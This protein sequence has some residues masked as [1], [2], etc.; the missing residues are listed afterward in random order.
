MYQV[1][2]NKGINLDKLSSTVLQT[3]LR[4]NFFTF[5][6]LVL[7]PPVFRLL[8]DLCA[9]IQWPSTFH[10]PP[11]ASLCNG[12]PL[13]TRRFIQLHLF[14]K[15]REIFVSVRDI[16]LKA[17]QHIIFF[18]Q[19]SFCAGSLVYITWHTNLIEGH[20]VAQLVEA[21]RYKREGRGF[22]SRRCH[23]NFSL[24]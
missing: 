1:G 8:P 4:L 17:D 21:L 15:L 18:P 9:T 7:P 6:I 20:A 14:P 11:A 5:L 10:T 2:I 13:I 19:N 23:R 24:T 3:K 22:D 16:I 12:G